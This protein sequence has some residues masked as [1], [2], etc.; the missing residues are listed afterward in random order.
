MWGDIHLH[1]YMH[2]NFTRSTAFIM[3]SLKAAILVVS[4]TA[5]QDPSTDA[6]TGVLAGVLKEAK[7]LVAAQQIVS[8]DV[9]AIQRQVTAWADD[10]DSPNLIITTGGTGFAVSDGTPEVW[11]PVN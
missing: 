7:W 3:E 11:T 10:A 4:T 8:D 2:L 6:A 5:A 9:L 1:L